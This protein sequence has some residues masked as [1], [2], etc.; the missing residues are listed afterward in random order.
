MS[1]RCEVTITCPKCNEEHP[2]VMWQ[3]INTQLDPEMRAAV[4]DR[5]AFQFICQTAH[6]IRLQ[7][8]TTWLFRL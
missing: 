2:F 8:R 1:K 3:S 5:S 6:I 4:K 7:I